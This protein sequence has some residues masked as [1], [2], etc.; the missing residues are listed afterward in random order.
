[1]FKTTLFWFLKADSRRKYL[2]FEINMDISKS[3]SYIH[4]LLGNLGKFRLII[5][6]TEELIG[7]NW[8]VNV[9]KLY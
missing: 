4:Y 7:C 3:H 5:T 9:Q 8:K 2:I 1:M 6:M